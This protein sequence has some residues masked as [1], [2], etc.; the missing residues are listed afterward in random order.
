MPAGAGAEAGA[1]QSLAV[2]VAASPVGQ[3]VAAIVPSGAVRGSAIAALAGLAVTGALAV[4][5]VT[6][7]SAKPTPDRQAL[8]APVASVPHTEALGEAPTNLEALLPPAEEPAP[9]PDTSLPSAP[10]TTSPPQGDAAWWDVGAGI[11]SQEPAPIATG[12]PCALSAE[13][14]GVQHAGS[15]RVVS[16][17]DLPD[18]TLTPT[19]TDA[20]SSFA[21]SAQFLDDALG[22]EPLHIVG[23]LCL[24]GS[25]GNSLSLDLTRGGDSAHLAALLVSAATGESSTTL[26][27]PGRFEWR[28]AVLGIAARVPREA[29]GA[30]RSRVGR[31]ARA[32]VDRLL[33]VRRRSPRAT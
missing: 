22:G 15:A 6:G 10:A 18:T 9:A 17:V 33:R 27:V 20:A 23:R 4:P 24:A 2:Q 16:K 29:R 8:S 14:A 28:P 12:S 3:A 13:E 30:Q 7:G 31:E 32:A 21:L 19:E 26:H 1:A 11:F 5:A 25:D